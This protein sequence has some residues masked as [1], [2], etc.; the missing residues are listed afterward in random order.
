MN[1]LW[2]SLVVALLLALAGAANVAAQAPAE[3][4]PQEQL[5]AWNQTATRADDVLMRREASTGLLETLRA[6]LAAQRA[7]ALAFQQ[8]NGER[9]ET[10]SAQLEALGP[11]PTNGV[12]EAEEITTR[13]RDLIQQ[14]TQITV[15]LL[16]AQ[17]A[18]S[19]ANALIGE[20]D[21]LIRARLASELV[22]LGPAAINPAYWPDAYLETQ[23]FVGRITTEVGNALKNPVRRS[24]LLR[25]LPVVA[26][27]LIAGLL[28]LIS[29]RRAALGRIEAGLTQRTALRE[30]VLW[31]AALNLGRLALPA[32]GAWALIWA[33]K[34][35][36][37][38]GLNGQAILRVLP[39]MAAVMIGGSWLAHSL[40]SPRLPQV[41]LVPLSDG[42]ARRASQLVHGLALVWAMRIVTDAAVLRGQ[43]TSETSGVLSFVLI[44]I[45]A[46]FLW[47][48][49][50]SLRHVLDAESVQ[51]ESVGRSF[52]IF[53]RRMMLV[54]SVFAP[55]MAAI[56]YFAFARYLFYPTIQTLALF[57]IVYVLV[58]LINDILSSLFS[59]NDPDQL[60][61]TSEQRFLPVAIGFLVACIALPFLALIWGARISD[62]TEAWVWVNEGVSIGDA[63]FSLRDLVVLVIVFLTGFSITRLLQKILRT[64]VLP[65]TRVDTGGRNAMLSGV[66]YVGYTLAALAA[67]SATGLDL[68]S[69]A[70]VA[71]ALS[72]G[73]GFGMQNVVS[74][75]VSGIILLIEQPIKEGDWIEVSGFTGYVRGI[76]VRSTLIETFD[77]GSVIVP[78]T[79]LIAGTVLNWTHSNLLGRLKVPVG[80]AYGTD[81]RLVERVLLEIAESHPM[82][83]KNPAP[84]VV[85]MGFGA[86]SLDFEIRAFLRDVNWML[87]AQSDMNF[88]IV[89]RFQQEG[90]EIP[91]A[92]RDI[93]FRDLKGIS[94]ALRDAIHPPKPEAAP[95][96]EIEP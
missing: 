49:A 6:E 40:F 18:Y 38:F 46:V 77:R 12:V 82:V 52:L 22:A 31:V 24:Y 37:I 81:P 45:G 21:T 69:L 27:A 87:S 4:T 92:Q 93:N 15:P 71:G 5:A 83:L 42:Q 25:Q 16:A 68:S 76:R 17:D 26:L 64:T 47:R 34:T 7:A 74:N 84:S 36:G 51:A 19:R 94:D 63:R 13:R 2:R 60:A 11:P 53:V 58:A 56:G 80:V 91:F 50:H 14:V 62:L 43:F 66:G 96:R 39:T 54:V 70:I 28:I 55:L 3:A 10:L 89:R 57:G 79:D 48:M 86:D 35:A 75:F 32:L 1:N 33:L 23:T 44:S 88:E 41:R 65:R 9:G 20:I 8:A 61:L 67:I 59:S 85:F 73:I 29:I 78:N 30:R 95:R 72:V 90:I